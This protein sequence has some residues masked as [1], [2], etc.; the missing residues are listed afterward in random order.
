MSPRLMREPPKWYNFRCQESD[1]PF[2]TFLRRFNMRQKNIL[3]KFETMKKTTVLLL[4]TLLTF[5]AFA[6]VSG[7]YVDGRSVSDGEGAGWSYADATLM[8][9]DGANVELS[10]NDA[11]SEVNI[12]IMDGASVSITLNGLVLR[13]LFLVGESS[14]AHICIDGE[15]E[16]RKGLN[17]LRGGCIYLD[18]GAHSGVG[19]L[20]AVG[21]NSNAAI[22]ALEGQVCGAIKIVGGRIHAIAGSL[23][24]AIGGGYSYSA[25]WCSSIEIEGGEV[26]AEA[27]HGAGIGGGYYAKESCRMP[28]RIS[29]GDV[30][31]IS[32]YGAGI[33]AGYFGSIGTI[34]ISGG[35]IDVEST[36]GAAIGCSYAYPFACDGV[37]IKGGTVLTRSGG[38]CEV[39]STRLNEG[40]CKY[41]EIS[42]GSVSSLKNEPNP[43]DANGTEVHRVVVRN[44]VWTDRQIEHISGLPDGYAVKDLYGDDTGA[45]YFWLRDGSYDLNVAG[46]SYHVTVA[47]ADCEAERLPGIGEFSYRILDT[48]CTYDAKPHSITVLIDEQEDIVPE[49]S[50]NESGP[51]A[52]ELP[53]FVNS[54]DVPVYVRFVRK[55]NVVCGDVGHVV[56]SPEDLTTLPV[57]LSASL[58]EYDGL[59]KRP[60]VGVYFRSCGGAVPPSDYTV[61]Y[62]SNVSVGTGSAIV[63]GTGNV[64]GQIEL[65][66]EI[67]SDLATDDAQRYMIID[68]SGGP[69]ARRYPVSYM[70]KIP[71]SGWTEE[72][73]SN[74]VVLRKVDPCEFMMGAN[75]NDWR[76]FTSNGPCPYE[77]VRFLLDYY[78]MYGWPANQH[79]AQ[80]QIMEAR[81][82][83]NNLWR[84]A[85]NIKDLLP[86]N[87]DMLDVNLVTVL[88]AKFNDDYKR[89]EMYLQGL[90][91]APRFIWSHQLEHRVSITKPYYMG[92]FEVTQRQFDLVVGENASTY[93]GDSRPVECIGSIGIRGENVGGEWPKTSA[94]DPSSFIGRLRRRTGGMVFDLPTEAQ[95]ECAARAGTQNLYAGANTKESRDGVSRNRLNCGDGKGGYAQHTMVGCY[96]PNA[97]GLYDMT[98]NVFEW[99]LDRL[100]TEIVRYPADA[101]LVDPVG[102]ETGSS[103]VCRGGA[104]DSDTLLQVSYRD[105]ANPAGNGNGRTGFRLA[106]QT[107][108]LLAPKGAVPSSKEHAVI[109]SLEQVLGGEPMVRI[110]YETSGDPVTTENRVL[111]FIDGYRD[112]SSVV[113]VKTAEVSQ[114]GLSWSIGEDVVGDNVNLTV[115]LLSKSEYLLPF[116]YADEWNVFTDDQVMDAL[117]WLYAGRDPALE[118]N[119]GALTIHGILIAKGRDLIDKDAAVVYILSTMGFESGLPENLKG[120]YHS[121]LA[122]SLSDRI[123]VNLTGFSKDRYALENG[124]FVEMFGI[125]L[126]DAAVTPF[127][128]DVTRDGNAD[129]ALFSGPSVKVYNNGNGDGEFD[130]REISLA[131]TDLSL[132]ANFV[133]SM[134]RPLFATDGHGIVYVSDGGD[135]VFAIS[136]TTGGIEP[137]NANG[138][139]LVLDGKLAVLRADGALLINPTNINDSVEYSNV[140]IP[141]CVSACVA[142]VDGDGRED[143]L[144]VTAGGS[145]WY[146]RQTSLKYFEVQSK[147]WAGSYEGLGESMS[148]QALD[149]DQDGDLDC[150]CGT[151]DG[152]LLLLRDPKVGRPVNLRAFSGVDNVQLEWTAKLQPR[153]CGYKIYRNDA[154]EAEPS[155][156]FW[157]DYSPLAVANY[158]VSAVSRYYTPGNSRPSVSESLKSEKIQVVVGDVA[159]HWNDVAVKQGERAEVMLS[160]ENSLNYDVAGKTQVVTYDPAYLTPL[161][162]VKTGL[163]ENVVYEES[164][165][166][167]KWTIALKSGSLAA[168]GGKFFTLVFDT[169]KAGTTKVGEATV[170]ITARNPENPTDVPPY[171]LGDVNGD[172]K[173]DQED[174]RELA[175]LKNGNG[176]KHTANQLKA[177]DF[178]GNGKLD[179]ADYQAL[180]ELLKEKGEKGV[181]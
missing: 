122:S 176:R 137:T 170:T 75:A 23:G 116:S 14:E 91:M 131:E 38:L 157:R 129:L 41:I 72:Y 57:S 82:Y 109:S 105:A 74:K 71:E 124:Q 79:V 127:V 111:A 168:G 140:A 100:S 45:L 46:C 66:F 15:N 25:S 56:I 3:N 181:L 86:V 96:R 52:A 115:L 50:L 80:L 126:F 162:I 36:C 83:L 151:V 69:N 139:P 47:G 68:I 120:E 31:A 54:G 5:I 177:G 167:G 87:E 94:V 81:N 59:P 179:N 20:R 44:K 128:D 30:R 169:L 98:G 6:D 147:T 22:G 92:V 166:D 135:A 149:W 4:S 55:G 123:E 153:I 154:C 17:A 103:R 164:V 121:G 99:C 62:E 148:I 150:L 163:T 146:Y 178:N 136:R 125:N 119:D 42:G 142:D 143:I 85:E 118:L 24:A 155:V 58:F 102:P 9:M 63:T 141:H 133:K 8:I 138:I 70:S 53:Q 84:K 18:D 144:A 173:L 95:W 39:G 165:A 175:R 113:P 114:N 104:W 78:E 112:W 35:R 26:V 43:T 134:T 106:C 27:V 11:Q 7:L 19:S 89:A 32:T 156:P 34:E 21:Y 180:R 159:F 117:F 130:L 93:R 10:G 1:K 101:V 13:G 132:V 16:L 90:E 48:K 171:S 37:T 152:R 67:S 172:G 28:I 33:G 2:I 40:L 174:V 158:C 161:K 77:R 64:L 12:T 65:P 145:I 160:I 60:W 97:W 49:Y 73:K 29:G 51:Y 61:R 110:E 88:M 107:V 76:D 108:D